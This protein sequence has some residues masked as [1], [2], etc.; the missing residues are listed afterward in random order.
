MNNRLIQM[1]AFAGLLVL[2]TACSASYV[3]TPTAGSHVPTLAVGSTNGEFLTAAPGLHEASANAASGQAPLCSA[4][5]SCAALGAEQ[6]PVGC[7]K[8]VPYTNVLVPKGTTFEVLD[9][10]GD[11]SCI[12]SGVQVND[13]EVLTCHGTPLVAFQLKLTN[14]ACAGT[15]LDT[16]TGQCQ[17]GYGY[18]ATAKCCAPVSDSS[19]GTATVTINLG[20][21]PLPS[22]P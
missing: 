12:D 22:N 11:F 18:D 9:Q 16:S 21:C 7:V 20:G 2:A 19:A 6:I 14:A 10:S 5:A 17:D 15:V 13:K 1:S 4:T 3:Q 8:K